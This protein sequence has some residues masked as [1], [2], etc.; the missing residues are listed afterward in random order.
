MSKQSREERRKRLAESRSYKWLQQV[1]EVMDRYYLDAALGFAVP[2]GIGDMISAVFSIGYILFSAIGLRS[3][4]LTLAV[5]NNILRDLVIGMIPFHIGDVVDVF[6]RSYKQNM[7]LI[8]GFVE[9]DETV[10]HV[11]NK[12]AAYSIVIFVLL[13]ALLY[14]MIRLVVWVAQQVF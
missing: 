4:P 7:V 10:I 5:A 14:A 12:K 3:F 2:G 6:H 11:V 8:R 1:A 9:G 13:C